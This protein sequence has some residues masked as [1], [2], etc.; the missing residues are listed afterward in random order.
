FRAQ[1][2]LARRSLERPEEVKIYGR[3]YPLRGREEILNG[4]S[5][6]ADCDELIL[7]RARRAPRLKAA[8]CV[9]GEG[10]QPEAMKE[11]LQN[12]GCS[13]VHIPAPGDKFPLT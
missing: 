12:A 10:P 8:F 1:D 3:L 7:G 2:A 9:H 4:S 11:I 13:D 6:H 5:A